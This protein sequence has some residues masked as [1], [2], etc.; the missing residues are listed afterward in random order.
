MS[1]G[2][3]DLLGQPGDL[4]DDQRLPTLEYLET[5][6][7]RIGVGH[8]ARRAIGLAPLALV[9]LPAQLTIAPLN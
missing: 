5:P 1:D 8:G 9:T 7:D 3:G 6:V 2:S 4:V